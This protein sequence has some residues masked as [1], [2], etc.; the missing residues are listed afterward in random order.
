MAEQAPER[1]PG[2][3]VL[4]STGAQLAEHELAGVERGHGVQQERRGLSWLLWLLCGC[5]WWLLRGCSGCCVAA[6]GC[7]G[8]RAR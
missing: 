7:S 2:A 5:S 1:L 4:V 6:R 3:V 8:C